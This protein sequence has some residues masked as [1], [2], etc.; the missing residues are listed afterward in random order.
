MKPKVPLTQER[1]RELFDLDHETG[2]MTRRINIGGGGKVGTVVGSFYSETR[3]L[4]VWIGGRHYKLH[5]VVF[6]YVHGYMPEGVIDHIDRNPLNNAP[7]NL[8]E[9]SQSCN[10]RNANVRSDNT[11][12]VKGVSWCES[13]S[14][15]ETFVSSGGERRFLGYYSD[16]TEAVAHRLAAEQYLGWAGCD[17]N[18]PAYQYMQKYLKGECDVCYKRLG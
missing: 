10:V 17:S 4:T 11:S 16:F 1:V 3:C 9:V 13:R 12:T 18:S 5:R 7:S 15:W 6:L 8:R 14:R 2:V